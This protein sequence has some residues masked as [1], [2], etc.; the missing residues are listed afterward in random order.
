MTLLHAVSIINETQTNKIILFYLISFIHNNTHMTYEET[1]F[2]P[3]KHH[4]D[5]WEYKNHNEW[6]WKTF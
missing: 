5:N 3:Q 6:I 4:K 2:Y 1:D